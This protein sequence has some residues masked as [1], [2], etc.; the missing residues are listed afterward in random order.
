MTK[1][2]LFFASTLSA[3]A[4]AIMVGVAH[5]QSW[6]QASTT[7]LTAATEQNLGQSVYGSLIV[8][9][10]ILIGL[11]VFFYFMRRLLGAGRGKH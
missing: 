4:S 2:K 10:P 6:S 7:A 1:A 9:I 5:A 11:A 8:V 3:V